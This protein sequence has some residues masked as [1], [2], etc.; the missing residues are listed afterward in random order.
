MDIK[1]EDNVAALTTS[2]FIEGFIAGLMMSVLAFGIFLWYIYWVNYE[3]LLSTYSL[4]DILEYN[5]LT[6]EDV[7]QFLVESKFVKLPDYQP[8]DFD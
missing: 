7:L 3:L 1:D 4:D 2:R 6:T 8:I 5:D